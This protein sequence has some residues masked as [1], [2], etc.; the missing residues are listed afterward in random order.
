VSPFVPT[1]AGVF[2]GSNRVMA[3]RAKKRRSC[4][5]K[6]K[7]GKP[8]KAPPLKPGTVINGGTADGK[9]C[10]QHDPN[11]PDSARM[12]GAVPGAGRPRR[13][14]VTETMREMVEEAG[15]ALLA[16]YLK[17]IGVQLDE[18][19]R[20][21]RDRHGHLVIGTGAQVIV[22]H[23]GEAIV[24]DVEDLAGQIAAVE[25]LL[26]RVYGRP[27]QATELTGKDGGPIEFEGDPLNGRDP[28]DLAAEARRAIAA[29]LA[30]QA[31]IDLEAA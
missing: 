30:K 7:A 22:K 28:V 18:H 23:E 24:A 21:T 11:L 1:A 20:P 3:E 4:K 14:R 19:G 29:E 27:T 15:H 17:S 5:G 9:H 31:G 12:G 10:R 26:D 8:C 25:K 2:P 13:P 16:P 6:T